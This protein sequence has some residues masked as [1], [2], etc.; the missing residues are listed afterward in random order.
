[1]DYEEKARKLLAYMPKMKAYK[2]NHVEKMSKGE[3]LMLNHLNFFG[4]SML[5]GD[6]AKHIEVST[7]RMAI[8]IKTT[9]EKGYVKREKV[10]SDRRK[11]VVV[12]TSQGKELVEDFY[13]QAIKD[14]VD[15]LEY[16]GPQNTENLFTL[17]EKSI[18][19]FEEKQA[20]DLRAGRRDKI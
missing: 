17:M 5:A 6:L 19:Y 8:I 7:A 3:L 2:N 9:E 4:G 18:N 13:N 1:M 20:D 11:T 15:F 14:T 16:I 12:L 10:E